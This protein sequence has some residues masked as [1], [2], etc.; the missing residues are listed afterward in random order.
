M[1]Q[2]LGQEVGSTLSTGGITQNNLVD[3]Q[4]SLR[5][6]EYSINGTPALP[7]LPIPSSLDL[8]GITPPTYMS[9]PPQ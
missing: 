9:N 3:L 2:I 6:N 5:H 1:P 7:N 4:T 8:N